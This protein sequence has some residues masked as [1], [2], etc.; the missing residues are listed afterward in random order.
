MRRS[1]SFSIVRALIAAG[2]VQPNPISM[3][4]KDLPDRPKRRIVRSM[5]N[6]VRERY[7]LSSNSDRKKNRIAICGKNVS[8]PPTPVS[9]PSHNKLM[10]HGTTPSWVSRFSTAGSS[11]PSSV[12]TPSDSHPPRPSNVSIKMSPMTAR[13]IGIPRYLFV[14]TASIRSLTVFSP[15][16]RRCTAWAHTREI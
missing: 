2:T 10:S 4:I 9:T 16:A 3:G 7:P 5:R 1:L 11:N 14:S 15:G 6:A 8:T 13:K 12:S